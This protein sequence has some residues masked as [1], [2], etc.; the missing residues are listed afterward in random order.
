MSHEQ[1]TRTWS[2]GWKANIAL[3]LRDLGYASL[4]DLLTVMPC[5]SYADIAERLGPNVAPIQVIAIQF[6]E[7]KSTLSVRQAAKD[8]L[9]RNIN[10]QLPHGWGRGR[11]SNWN[12]IMALSGCSSE[13]IAT[14]Q[15]PEL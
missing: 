6:E 15:C 13:I 1:T 3:R 5:Q 8:S 2:S 7:A 11:D 10:E 14:G 12:S 9:C 4:T